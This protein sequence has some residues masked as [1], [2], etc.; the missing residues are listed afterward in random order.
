VVGWPVMLVV[1]LTERDPA[2]YRTG[3][4]FRRCG[5]VIA[6]SNPAWRLHL[7]GTELIGDPRRPY[8]VVS[9][10][11]SLAD[12]PLISHVPMEMKWLAKDSLF[13]LPLLGWMMGLAGDIPVD[14]TDRRSGARALLAAGRMLANRCSVIFFPEGTRSR[15]GRVGAFNE[16]AFLLAIKAGVPVLPLAIDGSSD[17]LPKHSWMFGDVQDIRLQV[18]PPVETAGLSPRDAGVLRDRVRAAIV[19]QVAV[20]RGAAPADVDAAR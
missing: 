5:H 11:Q 3:W 12:I 9:N 16:G 4:T 15:D 2:R 20:W 10:H 1:R 17:C 13:R 19:A 14:R 6:R 18:L 8:V 7:G